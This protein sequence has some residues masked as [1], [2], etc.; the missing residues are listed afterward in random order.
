MPR[1]SIARRGIPAKLL[2]SYPTCLVVMI[3]G[4]VQV[5]NTGRA[6]F[7]HKEGREGTLYIKDGAQAA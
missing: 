2:R 7:S 3:D 5:I 6:V 1:K 4:A